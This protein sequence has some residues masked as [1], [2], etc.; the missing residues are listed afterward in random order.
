M[1]SSLWPF[2]AKGMVKVPQLVGL[3]KNVAIT[4]ITNSGL[5]NV[6]DSSIVTSDS[7]LDNKVASQVPVADT[8]VDYD[9]DVTFFYYT[10]VAPP[11]FPPTFQS[12]FF[13]PTFQSPFVP[14]TFQSPFF[15]PTF[16]SPFFPPTFQSP[17]FPPTFTPFFPPTF[18]QVLNYYGYCDLANNPVGP[19]STTL[20]CAEAY[21][22]QEDAN[23]YPPIGWVC[24]PTP[25]A[26]T[27]ECNIPPF[28]PPFF[29]PVFNPFFPPSFVQPTQTYYFCCDDNT[30]GSVSATSTSSATAAAETFCFTISAALTGIPST[31]PIE[32]CN[33]PPFFPPF[34][35]PSFVGTTQT[36]YFCC[37][38]NTVGT[39]SATSTA[40]A[41]NQ[42]ETF[43][44]TISAALTGIPSTAPI[45][46]CTQTPFFPPVFNPF[47]PPSFVQ[48]PFF[49]PSF[50]QNPFFPPTFNPF[51]PPSFV[52]PSQTYY[53]CCDD[54]TVGSVSATSS[55]AATNLAETFCFNISA[56]LTGSVTTSV[57]SSCTQ[58]P[59]FPPTFNPF[60][61]PTFNPF[62]PPSFQ[63]P[64][65]PPTFNPFFPPS[66]QNPFFPPTFNPFFPP[67]FVSTNPFFPPSFTPFFPPT[68]NPFF[69]PSFVGGCT[70]ECGSQS[71]NS[72]GCPPSM[73]C[74]D[75]A[76]GNCQF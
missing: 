62:F 27:P 22:I 19:F 45:E 52:T 1:L 29:P 10:Y 15:P 42:A 33:I 38:D 53:F 8:L 50:V 73:Y 44:F 37:D 66:F 14:P 23:G 61:P 28:F 41:T 69:P 17:F 49:P 36:Y 57:I 59:F 75:L 34:F 30:V 35:P 63:N 24:G 32:S 65:F 11:F 13:P 72:Y 12:P 39:V 25:A 67:S 9:T 3:L 47:F 18:Q 20:S 68:F 7:Q 54:N 76:C 5:K 71:S 48:N 58:T 74:S 16:Q 21:A 56:S 46:S 6:G 40:N 2:L 26:G 43:C 70:G 55:A 64:F 60:F 4:T 51:F 31:A